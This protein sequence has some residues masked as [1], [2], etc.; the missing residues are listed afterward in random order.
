MRKRNKKED[1]ER[2]GKRKRGSGEKLEKK[3]QKQRKRK[4]QRKTH[5]QST[6]KECRDTIALQQVY[7]I[8]I[9]WHYRTVHKKTLLLGFEVKQ[10]NQIRCG[11]LPNE[12]KGDKRNYLKNQPEIN[13]PRHSH[14][15]RMRRMGEARDR[16]KQTHSSDW[17]A[18]KI[19]KFIIHLYYQVVCLFVHFS[20]VSAVRA[21]R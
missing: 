7:D 20:S 5:S 13:A 1:Q 19:I 4:I 10:G 3:E 11:V 2:E 16:D 8:T 21:A 14:V 12:V 17:A 18:N 9:K 15:Q 6:K